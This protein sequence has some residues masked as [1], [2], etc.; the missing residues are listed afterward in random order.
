[1]FYS[2]YVF[3]MFRI[4]CPSEAGKYGVLPLGDGPYL[5]KTAEEI[6]GAVGTSEFFIKPQH[7]E[8]RN[9]LFPIDITQFAIHIGARNHMI[10][11]EFDHHST[12]EGIILSSGN[13]FGGYILYVKDN[14]VIYGY[15]FHR[16]RVFRAQSDVLPEG[17][18]KVNVKFI[19]ADDRK[20]AKAE[21]YVNGELKDTATIDGFIM[22]METHAFIKDGGASAVLDDIKLPFVY[23]N[24]I[25]RVRF[26]A[27]SVIAKRDEVLNQFNE[28]D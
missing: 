8:Y 24:E 11:A 25:K 1:M 23:P 18:I 2:F 9:I 15:N 19:Y 5:T 14:K 7:Y 26:D 13:R 17:N 16:E 3:S 28:I 27:A 12:D 4:N 22:M 20:T 6:A 21:L 10:T